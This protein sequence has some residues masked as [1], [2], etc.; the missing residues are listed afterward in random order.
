MPNSQ[1]PVF[2]IGGRVRVPWGADQVE[3]EIV[4]VWGDP[5]A[6]LRVALELEEDEAPEVLLL[7]PNIVSPVA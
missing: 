7:R 3:G 2:H 5:P 1:N 6:H 4:E